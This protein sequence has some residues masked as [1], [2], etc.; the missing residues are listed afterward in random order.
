MFSDNATFRLLEN[1]RKNK[2][3]I[4]DQVCYKNCYFLKNF[5]MPYCLCGYWNCTA[6]SC[7]T[8][9][10]KKSNCICNL[11][12]KINNGLCINVWQEINCPV[13]N[14]NISCIR[15]SQWLQYNTVIPR[16]L[17]VPNSRNSLT[18]GSARC[19][20]DLETSKLA[21]P[22]LSTQIRDFCYFLSPKIREF[23][24]I[25]V[26]HYVSWSSK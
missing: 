8:C 18:R 22:L 21:V 1:S 4:F 15:L 7:S 20:W 25:T 5:T 10:F 14:C 26:H 13:S 23:G 11:W 6:C 12:I 19:S 9:K 3:T 16:K 17:A 24:G 2:L